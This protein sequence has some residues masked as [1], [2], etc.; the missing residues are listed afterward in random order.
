MANL[1]GFADRLLRI[2]LGDVTT[3]TAVSAILKMI[4]TNAGTP[5]DGTSGTLAGQAPRGALLINTSA[6]ELYQNTN[7]MASPTWTLRSTPATTAA[8]TTL[9]PTT[10]PPTTAPPTTV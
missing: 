10:A 2:A 5:T 3:G 7:T 8:P 4:N 6:A 1:T 9:P